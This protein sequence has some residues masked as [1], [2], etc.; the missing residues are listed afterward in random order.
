MKPISNQLKTVSDLSGS[1]S[2]DKSL[3]KKMDK[4]I[5]KKLNF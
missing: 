1:K 3:L 4:I 2:P 5:S